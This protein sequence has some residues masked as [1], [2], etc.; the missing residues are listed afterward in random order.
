MFRFFRIIRQKLIE[1]KKIK[2]YFLYAIGE[3]ILVVIGIFIAIQLN[4]LN[5]D[6]K[7]KDKEKIYY[8]KL[9]ED[10][11]QDALEVDRLIAETENRIHHSNV[12]LGLLQEEELDAEKI[13]QEMFN[14]V[15]FVTFTFR[16]STAS[17]EDIKS[18]GNLG[19][20]DEDIKKQ[21]IEFY[22]YIDGIVDV[23][24]INS[25]QAVRLFQTNESFVKEGWQFIGVAAEAIDSTLVDLDAL[26]AA[27][28]PYSSREKLMSDALYYIGSGSRVRML[29][30][31]LKDRIEEMEEI[32][33]AQCD[34][35]IDE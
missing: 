34:L 15:A 11:R 27:A 10:V 12:F 14:S 9:L 3:I 24:N 21:L 17:F 5:E 28:D 35:G 30:G 33:N 8:C 16:P 29:Y 13:A 25:D 22:V 18:S 2:S 20:L 1:S 4:N 23:V 6:R 7:L 26:H 31:L 19:V 32:L